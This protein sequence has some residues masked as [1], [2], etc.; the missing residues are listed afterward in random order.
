MMSKKQNGIFDLHKSFEQSV[1]STP[2]T[3]LGLELSGRD[4][5]TFSEALTLMTAIWDDCLNGDFLRQRKRWWET[6]PKDAFNLISMLVKTADALLRI[7]DD[8]DWVDPPSY[9]VF[10]RRCAEQIGRGWGNTVG[11]LKPLITLSLLGNRVAIKRSL[12]ALLF[13][14]KLT[15]SSSQLEDE[16]LAGYVLREDN[17]AFTADVSRERAIIERWFPRADRS[18]LYSM[19]KPQHGNGA[20]ADAG[21]DIMSKYENLGTSSAIHLLCCQTGMDE[22]AGKITDHCSKTTFVPKTYKSYRTISAEPAT[23][24]WYQEGIQKGIR[25][26]IQHKYLSRRFSPED[27]IPSRYYACEGSRVEHKDPLVTLDLSA[28][29]DSVSEALVRDLFSGSALNYPLLCSRSTETLLPNGKIIPLKKYAPMG[30]A[31]TFDVMSIILCAVTE[32]VIE[33]NGG[34]PA[35]SEYRIYGDDI[36]VEASYADSLIFRLEQLGFS[37][38]R[39]KSFCGCGP[40]RFRESCGGFFFN[41]DDVTPVIISRKFVGFGNRYDR[42]LRSVALANLFYRSNYLHQARAWVIHHGI[43]EQ[44]RSADLWPVFTHDPSLAWISQEIISLPEESRPTI[45]VL[46]DFPSLYNRVVKFDRG[47]QTWVVSSGT[48]VPEYG[49]YEDFFEGGCPET[50]LYEWLRLAEESPD[51]DYLKGDLVLFPRPLIER[52]DGVRKWTAAI[53]WSSTKTLRDLLA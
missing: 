36:I 43:L 19:M 29:S 11:P 12:Q 31:C 17:I 47:L 26:Y 42:I 41:G 34:I 9:D 45:G 25:K 16:A 40:L 13:L 50:A 44:L 51:R 39:E 1:R 37:V 28:A 7:I 22:W 8:S 35:L 3:F 10:K 18:T 5:N 27:Q 52:R 46:S 53:T 48:I 24:M 21:T 2:L 20:T 49:D 14:K 4:K 23:L 15:L 38:N 33:R 30:N 32:S 6:A